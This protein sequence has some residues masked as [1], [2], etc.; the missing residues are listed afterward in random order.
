MP[1]YSIKQLTLTVAMRF[2]PHWPQLACTAPSTDSA[3]MVIL[4]HLLYV[5]CVK[6]IFSPTRQISSQIFKKDIHF[7][8]KNNTK[9]IVYIV[10]GLL[11]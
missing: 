8:F 1:G 11:K 10:N 3:S 5:Q 9:S 2:S 6:Q 4:T 7:F